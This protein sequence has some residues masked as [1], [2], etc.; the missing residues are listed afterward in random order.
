MGHP[1]GQAGL[2]CPTEAAVHTRQPCPGYL[3]TSILRIHPTSGLSSEET[4]SSHQL[5]VTLVVLVASAC[6]GLVSTR[7]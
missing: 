3:V 4:T 1:L 2:L 7:L 5:P 6:G